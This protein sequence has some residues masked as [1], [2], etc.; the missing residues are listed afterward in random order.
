MIMHRIASIAAVMVAAGLSGWAS[1]ASPRIQT[2]PKGS[3]TSMPKLAERPDKIAAGERLPGI[4]LA[5][6]PENQRQHYPKGSRNL[7]I[8]STAEEAETHEKQ[9]WVQP[10]GDGGCFAVADY[11]QMQSDA[12]EWAMSFSLRASMHGALP[13]TPAAEQYRQSGV[14]AVHVE[15]LSLQGADKAT[16]KS[17]DAWVD[18][19]TMGVRSRREASMALAKVADGPSGVRVFAARDESDD[20]MHFV[21]HVPKPSGS[22]ANVVGRH[23]MIMKGGQMGSSDCGFG[24]L[25][26][27]HGPGTGDRGSIQVEV[28]LPSDEKEKSEPE[29][30]TKLGAVASSLIFGKTAQPAQPEAREVRVR[31]LLVHVSVSQ[32]AAASQPTASV[33]F[34]WQGRERRMQ[35]F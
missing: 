29:K 28:L 22:D 31:T 2:L 32:T 6:P 23:F 5:Q 10:D 19:T 13:G 1:G 9:G 3:V 30:S 21:V 35:V 14:Q 18:L 16:L 26:L 12:S 34:G 27:R 20:A 15:R 24:R 17:S 25:S 8:Y 33:S 4:F 11:W 7:T